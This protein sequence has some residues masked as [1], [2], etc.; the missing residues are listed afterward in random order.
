M[1][2]LWRHL[3]EGAEQSNGN[4]NRDSRI[5]LKFEP[6]TPEYKAKLLPLERFSP[7]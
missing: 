7:S 6:S 2:V 3:L 5:S 1:T 4:V